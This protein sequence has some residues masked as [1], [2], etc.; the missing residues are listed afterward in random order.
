MI[1]GTF[2]NF[3]IHTYVLLLLFQT[4]YP[5]ILY[6]KHKQAAVYSFSTRVANLIWSIT[7]A[8]AVAQLL[9]LLLL[10][11]ILN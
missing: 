9:L 4:N 8:A 11:Q 7:A 10:L 3:F 5:S 1:G 6:I 2:Q